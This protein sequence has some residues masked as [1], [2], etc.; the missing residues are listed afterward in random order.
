ME[1]K[2]RRKYSVVS[3]PFS[4]EEATQAITELVEQMRGI[5]TQLAINKPTTK[6]DNKTWEEFNDW[7]R[8]AL[9]AKQIMEKQIS[10]L[11]SWIR[12]KKEEVDEHEIDSLQ[13]ELSLCFQHLESQDI[14]LMIAV[15][16]YETIC[17]R[18]SIHA[19]PSLSEK[20]RFAERLVCFGYSVFAIHASRVKLT[21]YECK[22][23]DRLVDQLIKLAFGYDVYHIV[24]I[25]GKKPD[26]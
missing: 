5:E 1:V 24:P 11:K 2:D 6:V 23:R 25:K 14:G 26:L 18:G 12:E 22:V 19:V 4:I 17:Q 9:R 21:P 20:K 7:K 13:K 10:F 8:R 16:N 3:P 15:A